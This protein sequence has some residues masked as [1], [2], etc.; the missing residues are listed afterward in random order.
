M[1]AGA[2]FLALPALSA[3]SGLG[4]ALIEAEAAKDAAREQ[5]KGLKEAREF[6]EQ[7]FQRGEAIQQ[8]FLETGSQAFQTLADLAMQGVQVDPVLLPVQETQ[9]FIPELGQFKLEDD[10][11]FQFAQEQAR[12][13]VMA[14]GAAQGRAL[15]G[16]TLR[17]LQR[18]AAGL[19]AQQAQQA[20]GRF[21]TQ[22]QMAQQRG[23]TLAGLAQSQFGQQLGARQ[24]QQ[25]ERQQALSNLAGI[26]NIGPRTATALS[27]LAI[28]QGTT[29]GDLA[30]QGGNIRAAQQAAQ[31]RAFSGG[32]QSATGGLQ[33]ALVI[34]SLLK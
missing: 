34:Q 1:G 20:F 18:E 30:I 16:S 19:A 13:A 17:D 27:N 15:S 29:L 21:A 5:R 4:S 26:A 22:Q 25:A 32:L 3:L 10:P 31:G 6:Q 28:G 33:D 2:A 12:K 23:Q 24:Q 11:G 8:P 14:R 9:Q 7:A